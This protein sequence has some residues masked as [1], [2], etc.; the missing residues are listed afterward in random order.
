MQTDISLDRP[1][2]V[3]SHILGVFNELRELKGIDAILDRILFEA[4]KLARADAGSIFL[5]EHG[6]LIFSHVH[7][8]TLFPTE[9]VTQHA[10]LNASL[11]LDETSIAGYV[12]SRGEALVFA[13]VYT[14]EDSLSCRFNASFDEKTGYRTQSM[15][16][17][18]VINSQS[19]V[20][21]V[22]Q[23][24]NAKAPDG[25]VISFSRDAQAYI[26]LL[27][28]HAASVIETGIMTNEMVLRMIKM[29]ELRDP[30]ETG[31]HV[32]RVG[33]YAA[34]IFHVIA[35]K[36]GMENREVKR[37][38]DLI[39]IASMLHDV[40]KVGVPDGILK[41]PGKLTDDEYEIMKYHTVYGARLFAQTHSELDVMARDIALYHHQRWDGRGGYPGKVGDL[42][43]HYI[44]SSLPMAGEDIPLAARIVALADVFDALVSMRSYKE[45]WPPERAIDLI[46]EERGSQFDPHV[47]DAFLSLQDV[48]EAIRRKFV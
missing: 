32:Q 23:I 20:V 38:K 21:A 35:R 18:P 37:R 30:A 2:E 24:I 33:A 4:R 14:I 11:P 9:D 12:A 22:V 48:I 10:Y 16:T 43:N 34:E 31:A 45:P 5:V 26:S 17:A 41:K 3:L 25:S 29:A 6:K 28:D 19:K 8:D 13:D 7:N 1:V 39:R 40:G 42:F 44:S 36:Q 46:R 47:V 15:F 27:A